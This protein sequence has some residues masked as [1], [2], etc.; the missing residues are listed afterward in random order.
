MRASYSSAIR[1]SGTL[2]GKCRLSETSRRR[3]SDRENAQLHTSNAEAHIGWRM[4][5]TPGR[6]SYSDAFSLTTD[7]SGQGCRTEMGEPFRRVTV[8]ARCAPYGH[9]FVNSGSIVGTPWSLAASDGECVQ[10][11]R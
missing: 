6:R 9:G 2:G 8:P 3:A 10:E 11:P 4:L 5:V 1:A 7:L